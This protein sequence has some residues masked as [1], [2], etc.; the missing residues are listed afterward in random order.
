MV[1]SPILFTVTLLTIDPLQNN[2][3]SVG[4]VGSKN[5]EDAPHE[6]ESQFLLRLPQV[7]FSIVV[8]N[9]ISEIKLNILPNANFQ[10]ILTDINLKNGGVESI[11][12]Y[13]DS[14]TVLHL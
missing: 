6:L 12:W 3:V 13:D 4:K 1:I 14:P 9:L 5:K 10:N 8:Y 7:C 11:M 2:F